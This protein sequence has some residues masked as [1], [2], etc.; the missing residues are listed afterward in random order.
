MQRPLE[1]KVLEVKVGH[2][3]QDFHTL[4]IIK[5]VGVPIT[6]IHQEY[7]MESHHS[8]S[9][10]GQDNTKQKQPLFYLMGYN[11]AAAADGEQ[12]CIDTD[13]RH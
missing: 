4:S 1:G 5:P 11:V 10:S 8:I 7:N 2:I 9:L 13:C 6:H 12:G 3:E